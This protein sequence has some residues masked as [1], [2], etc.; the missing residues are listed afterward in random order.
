[1]WLR[2]VFFV[3]LISFV[4]P[5]ALEDVQCGQRI[6]VHRGNIVSGLPVLKGEFPWLV[7]F[8]FIK[9]DEFFCSGSLISKDKVVSGE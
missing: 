8:W 1:M 3:L 7:A 6:V 5:N 2:G 9:Q 4:P